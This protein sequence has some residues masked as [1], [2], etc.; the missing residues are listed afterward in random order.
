MVD[1]KLCKMITA[2][3]LFRFEFSDFKD[4]LSSISVKQ[5]LTNCPNSY[6]A[7]LIAS[8]NRFIVPWTM[9]GCYN[10]SQCVNSKILALHSVP[11]NIDDCKF[12]C[13]QPRN[14]NVIFFIDSEVRDVV[15]GE[16]IVRGKINLKLIN[17]SC[18]PLKQLCLSSLGLISPFCFSRL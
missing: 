14:Y 6:C 8:N 13:K 3:T 2:V 5:K 9:N 7:S 15:L 16:H 11:I 17:S 1:Y 18:L 12:R 4:S 10:A